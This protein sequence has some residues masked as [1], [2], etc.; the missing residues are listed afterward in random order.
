MNARG[1]ASVL[2]WTWRRLDGEALDWNAWDQLNER[3]LR[4]PF[5]ESRFLVPALSFLREAPCFLAFGQRGGQTV[6]AAI[7]CPQGRGRWSLFQP[8]Q[9]PLG[10]L[11]LAPDLTLAEAARTLTAQLPGLGLALSLTQLDPRLIARPAPGPALDILAY[12]ETAWIEVDRS[13]EEFLQE[14]GKNLRANLRKG[15]AKL[16]GG[17]ATVL[18]E[19][20]VDPAAVGEALR[21]YAELEQR[22]WKGETGTAVAVGTPQGDFYEEMMRRFCAAGRGEIWQLVVGERV[23]AMDLC[24]RNDEVLVILKTA[25]DPEF[26]T[27]SPGMLLKHAAFSALFAERRVRRIEFYGRRMD[28]HRRWTD[29]YCVLYHATAFRHP[30]LLSAYR[31]FSRMRARLRAHPDARAAPR[32]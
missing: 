5:F 6:G 10:P 24:I 22:G 13:Y 26:A 25:Y 27:V 18:F 7:V 21:T 12:L 14:R 30:W 32:Q 4:L 11:L 19:R 17:L 8:S 9:L 31:G 2:T 23:I 1:E 3:T 16:D 15:Q 29:Q 20:F 28:W